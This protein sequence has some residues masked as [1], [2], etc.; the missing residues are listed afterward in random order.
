MA[1]TVALI[2]DVGLFAQSPPEIVGVTITTASTS[3]T[4]KTITWTTN[5][6][7]DSVIN[8]GLTPD[9][10]VSRDSTL[11]KAHTLTVS[12]LE[13][14]RI[15]HFR[16]SS[17]D[18]DGNQQ[19]SGN[20]SF[21]TGGFEN[22]P[23]IDQVQST[24]QKAVVGQT[25]RA[26]DQVTDPKALELIQ[27]KI[28]QVAEDIIRPPSII[29]KPNVID[30]GTDYAVVTWSTDREAGSQVEYATEAEYTVNQAYSQ[31]QGV[32]D[33][34][35]SHEVRLTGL[36]PSTK[37]HFRVSSE[38]NLNM[39]GISLDSTFE[40]KSRL[41]TIQD[42][43][44][45]KLEED[46]ATIAWSTD[47]PA[48]GR[49]DFEDTGS[50]EIRTVGSPEFLTTHTVRISDLTLGTTYVAIIKSENEAGDTVESE[51]ITFTTVRDVEAPIISRVANES[52]LFPG[53]ETRIQT[54]ISWKTDEPSFC[55]MS[56]NE[57]LATAENA[58][59]LDENKQTAEDHVQ[60]VVEFTPSTV[61]KFWIECRDRA[62]NIGRSEDFVLFTPEKE[63]SII[64][65]ILENFEGTF[66]WVK[67]I[68]G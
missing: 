7:S 19:V 60:V 65:I 28:N 13:P 64:D 48:A 40:T 35:Q 32:P 15:Y 46:S 58:V 31:T 6:D 24:E 5:T 33:M 51:P 21:V 45:I 23:N 1:L 63:K 3:A 54:I 30:I 56:F 41:P 42:I 55:A 52:T 11:G 39:K 68:G 36:L 53:A 4:S 18:I 2:P 20:Y 12:D 10:G 25:Y 66:G 57:G 59:T 34:T 29:G 37:Y 49:I 61:Y 47:F 8:Y 22:I 14:S 9:Y 43:E 62:G 17:T 67:N 16:V 26:L 50:G 44:V 27:D 38:D